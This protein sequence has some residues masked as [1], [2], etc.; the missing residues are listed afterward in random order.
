MRKKYCAIF[1]DGFDDIEAVTLVNLLRRSDIEVDVYGVRSKNIVSFT[2]MTY[3]ADFIFS[4]RDDIDC[5]AYD[6]ILLPR[7]PGVLELLRNPALLSLIKDFSDAGKLMYAICGAPLLLEKAGVLQNRTFTCLPSVSEMIKT[8]TRL[9]KNV[10]VDRNL[11]TSKALGT[12]LDGAL[13]LIG[14]IA[15]EG[16]RKEIMDHYYLE[17]FG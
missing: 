13:A 2:R 6:G 9:E 12:S 17:N 7:G 11:V 15:S 10:V 16:K 14:V 5:G 1:G 8:G 3:V 4:E